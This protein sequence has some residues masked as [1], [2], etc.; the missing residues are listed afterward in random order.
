MNVRTSLVLA[1]AIGLF[2]LRAE[3]QSVLFDF[4][5]LPP[6]T[7]LPGSYTV[8]GITASFSA[9]GQG[10]SIQPANTMGFT[11]LGFAGNCIY[12]N[13]VF[14]A[15]LLVGFSAPLSGFS[16]LYAPQELACDDSATMRVTA[17]LGAALVGTATATAANPGTWPSETLAFNSAQ[18]FDRVVVHYAARPPTC[19]DWGPIFMADNMH[20]T[21]ARAAMTLRNGTTLAGGAVQFEFTYSSGAVCSAYVT[22]DA[23]I[24]YDAWTFLATATEVSPGQFQF[25]DPDA[26]ASALLFY[27]ATCP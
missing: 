18:P 16:I 10:F 26:G 5:G 11:P 14:A 2:A 25:V 12:P 6:H 23:S 21:P 15:D 7:G 22:P 1:S 20:V 17:Y 19:G 4:D 13:S 8:G 9:T 27:R 3:A 24:A